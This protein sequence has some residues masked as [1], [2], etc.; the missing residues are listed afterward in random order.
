MRAPFTGDAHEMSPMVS[1][2]ITPYTMPPHSRPLDRWW[3][4]YERPRS[5]GSQVC[6]V[7]LQAIGSRD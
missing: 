3:L 5:P 1:T 2:H 6:A 4:W 7:P